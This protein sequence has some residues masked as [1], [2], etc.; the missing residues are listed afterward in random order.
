MTTPSA[1]LFLILLTL[2]LPPA[3]LAV[4][5]AYSAGAP[6]ST[7]NPASIIFSLKSSS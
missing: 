2:P 3:L 6:F 4:Q 1:A 5:F 7:G